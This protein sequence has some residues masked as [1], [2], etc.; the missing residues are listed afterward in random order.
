MKFKK[1]VSAILVISLFASCDPISIDQPPEDIIEDPTAV[2]L[3]F[4]ENNTECNEG[5]ILSDTESKVTFRWDASE[6]TDSYELVLTNTIAKETNSYDAESN[7]KEITLERGTN[8]E[9]LV[10]SK[11]EKSLVTTSSDTFQFFNAG[12]GVVNHV[13]FSAVALSPENNADVS[14]TNGKI[15]LQ[16]EAS[17]VD[18]DIKDYEIFFGTVKDQLESVGITDSSNFELDVTSGTSYFW[19]VKTNDETNNSANSETFSFNV[20]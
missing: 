13:P 14:A 8:Y 5:I 10:I 20:L 12:P 3:I 7:S 9:W 4:P 2:N 19:M 17:D 11:S 18:D 1:Y 6:H 15:S 16:W